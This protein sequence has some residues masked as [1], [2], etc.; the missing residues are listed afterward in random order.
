MGKTVG[1]TWLM[2]AG[3]AARCLHV[4]SD[5]RMATMSR[6]PLAGSSRSGNVPASAP[7]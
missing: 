5:R 1:E 4:V 2:L 6:I 3:A 7:V